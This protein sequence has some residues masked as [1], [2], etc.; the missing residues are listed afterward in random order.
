[1]GSYCLKAPSNVAQYFRVLISLSHAHTHSYSSVALTSN[2]WAPKIVATNFS[3]VFRIG[4][5]ILY[6]VNKRM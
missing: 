4:N 6:P 3:R 2:S 1:M 5:R